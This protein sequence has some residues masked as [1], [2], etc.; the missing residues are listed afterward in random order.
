MAV[1]VAKISLPGGR[2][3]EITG[4][5]T[6]KNTI[7]GSLRHLNQAQLSQNEGVTVF[8]RTLTTTRWGRTPGLP[9]GRPGPRLHPAARERWGADGAVVWLRQ[10]GPGGQF[11]PTPTGLAR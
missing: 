8:W 1:D 10:F 3:R 6:G 2:Q 5:I 7:F 4:E 9:A 11:R